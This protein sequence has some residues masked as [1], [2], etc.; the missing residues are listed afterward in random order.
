VEGLEI[1]TLR[2]GLS[3]ASTWLFVTVGRALLWRAW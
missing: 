3:H 2:D 1:D